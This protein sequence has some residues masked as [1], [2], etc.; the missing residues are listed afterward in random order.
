MRPQQTLAAQAASLDRAIKL[1][2]FSL[3]IR[4][5]FL[6]PACDNVVISAQITAQARW[7]VY[8]FGKR[9]MRGI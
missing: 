3:F 5:Y 8:N 2:G 4:N 9:N 6:R 1:Q 7:N